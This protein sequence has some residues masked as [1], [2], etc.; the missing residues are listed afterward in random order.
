MSQSENVCN[1]KEP[2]FRVSKDEVFECETMISD[3]TACNGSVIDVSSHGL[4][5][6]CEGQFEVGMKFSTEFKTKRFHGTYQG[7]IRRVEPW[8]GTQSLLGCEL[9]EPIQPEILQELIAEGH[10]RN[11]R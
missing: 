2:R 10:D 3:A 1:R 9:S 4:R 5:L 6:L 8:A 7:V 11:R